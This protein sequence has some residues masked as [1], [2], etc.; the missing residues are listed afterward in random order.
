MHGEF[1]LNARKTI[2][3]LCLLT[4]LLSLNACGVDAGDTEHISKEDTA[5]ISIDNISTEHSFMPSVTESLDVAGNTYTLADFSFWLPSGFTRRAA[6]DLWLFTSEEDGVF[7]ALSTESFEALYASGVDVDI[8]LEEYTK[9]LTTKEGIY[10]L[11]R[12][13]GDAACFEYTKEIENEA[14]RY[15]VRVY[16]GSGAF[17]TMQFS[18][19][20]ADTEAN[21]AYFEAITDSVK[22][23]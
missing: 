20:A 10:S 17:Y 9:R 1:V 2:I 22:V 19:K 8:S 15:L 16:K 3:S 6:N 7:I 12:L 5:H 14:Y 4:A 13:E 18:C 23:S 21:I 11:V